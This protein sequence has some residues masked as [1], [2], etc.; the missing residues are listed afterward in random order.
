[1]KTLRASLLFLC[2]SVAGSASADYTAS[3]DPT[4]RNQTW[5]GWG[6]SLAW[7]AHVVGGYPEPLRSKLCDTVFNYLG[8]TVARY[9]IGGGEAPGYDSMEMRARVPG[10]LRVTGTYDWS[11]DANQR[12]VL[13]RAKALGANKFEAFS[14][15]P[16]YWMTVSGSVTG[17]VG[18]GDNLKP[19]SVGEFTEYLSTVVQRFRDQWG[20]EF[21]T[22]APLNEPA[23]NWWTFGGRQEG[24]HV[25]PGER[26]SNL[27]L[28][29]GQSLAGK[30]LA[31][32]VS[33]LEESVNDWSVT[34]WDALS[35]QAKAQVF[36][37]NTH[38][39]GGNS[40]RSVL[41]RATRSGKRLWMSEYGD[42]DAS[43][44][45]MAR[46]IVRDLRQMMPTA[47]VYWQAIDGGWGWGCLDVDLNA[48]AQTY[49][50][51]KKLYAFANFT[52]FIRPGAQFVP[53]SDE[54][55]VASIRGGL[56]TIVTVSGD[57]DEIVDYDLSRFA[58]VG[59]T[60]RLYRTSARE[61]LKD[62]GAF[63]VAKKRMRLGVPRNSI[64]TIV[65]TGVGAGAPAFSGFHTLTSG[66]TGWLLDVPGGTWTEGTALTTWQ[67]NGGLNQQWRV[68]GVGDGRY[69]FVSRETGLYAALWDDVSQ[70]FPVLQWSNNGDTTLDWRLT[71]L[72]GSYRI[73]PIRHPGKCLVENPTRG[74]GWPDVS[75]YDWYAGAEQQWTFAP[76][77]PLFPALPGSG[78]RGGS[79]P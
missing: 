71:S 15:S 5:E 2:L 41:H 7:W 52:K 34:S 68:E 18:G 66:R 1:M 78:A 36:R 72:G 39:Y 9:N 22:L 46:Q 42:G 57:S 43:G 65:V 25:S 56:L 29:A 8:L 54:R 32:R 48:G 20:I 16:P 44:M 40:Q 30:G 53:I 14:N 74:N 11:A 59:K 37:V 3:V 60:A 23:A 76:A 19:E 33:G 12:W 28:S 47:W 17:A 79:L 21:E 10:F 31:T 6:T 58:T 67:S 75:I 49:T 64:T 27:I 50:T 35:E 69:R 51:N 45:T 70:N 4:V 55:S 24:C 62:L 73:E 63:P 26:Q 38:C 77:A 61:N 13:Q